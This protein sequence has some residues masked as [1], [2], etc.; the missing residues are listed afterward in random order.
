MAAEP[1]EPNDELDPLG[2]Y[3]SKL[4]T[5]S[6]ILLLTV[7]AFLMAIISLLLRLANDPTNIIDW[8]EGSLQNFSTELFGAVITFITIQQIVGGR[9][10]RQQAARQIEEEKAQLDPPTL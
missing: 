5:R 9:E 4:S 7:A 1:N 8:L 6:I 2:R 10:Q 3:L